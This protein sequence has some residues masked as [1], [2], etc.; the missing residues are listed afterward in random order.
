[1]HERGLADDELEDERERLGDDR[2]VREE[3]DEREERVEDR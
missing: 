2:F 1:M 3:R